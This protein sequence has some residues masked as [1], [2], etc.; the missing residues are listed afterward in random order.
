[1]LHLLN[2]IF[3]PRCFPV[4][5]SFFLISLCFLVHHFYDFFYTFPERLFI[6]DHCPAFG[7]SYTSSGLTTPTAVTIGSSLPIRVFCQNLK[8]QMLV[9]FMF[10]PTPS[11]SN[12][13]FG[14]WISILIRECGTR[15]I[16]TPTKPCPWFSRPV[17]GCATPAPLLK[18]FATFR[19]TKL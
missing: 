18:V 14:A 5:G 16:S 13:T 7:A 6:P 1:M 11:N 3:I 2:F 4:W 12:K 10:P 19:L 15:Y 8:A 17:W 9:F